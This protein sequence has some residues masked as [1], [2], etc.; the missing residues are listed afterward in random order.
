MEPLSQSEKRAVRAAFGKSGSAPLGFVGRVMCVIWF[1]VSAVIA[2]T[3]SDCI[4]L[5]SRYGFT[6]VF[7][8]HIHFVPDPGAHKFDD[9]ILSNGDHLGYYERDGMAIVV[10]AL[11][12]F[13][14]FIG[15]V[16]IKYCADRMQR[17]KIERMINDA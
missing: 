3:I 4:L 1:V 16:V 13:F 15:Y 2:S 7:R 12:L 10:W 17:S 8:E 11:L 9:A 14:F 6:R 5:V